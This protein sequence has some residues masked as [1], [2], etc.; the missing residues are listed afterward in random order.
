MYLKGLI[1]SFEEMAKDHAPVRQV[2]DKPL[3]DVS[4]DNKLRLSIQ[5][6]EHFEIMREQYPDTY[7]SLSGALKRYLVACEHRERKRAERHDFLN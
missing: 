7:S 1:N 5:T 2:I 6:P 3:D 4:L